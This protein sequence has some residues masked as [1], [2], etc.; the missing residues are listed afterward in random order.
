MLRT[1]EFWVG[2]SF[3]G[4]VALLFYYR[5]HAKIAEALDQRAADIK[6][7]LDEAKRLSEEAQAILADYQR[8]QRDAEK[9]AKAIIDLAKTEAEALAEETRVALKDSLERRTRLAEDKIARAE[10]Q[11]IDE[12]RATAVEVAVGAA[13]KLITKKLTAKAA[14]T[15]ID[16][17]IKDLKTKL[18]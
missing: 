2:V 1:P 8:K 16:G 4:F 14:S 9:E 15:L 3:F 5:V 13:E 10:A 17:S 6:A 7:E 11:A 12:V 18:N